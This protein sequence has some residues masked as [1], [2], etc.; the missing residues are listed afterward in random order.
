MEKESSGAV[1]VGQTPPTSAYGQTMQRSS[2]NQSRQT[3][4]YLEESKTQKQEAAI[5]VR[6]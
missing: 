3:P 5:R 4:S 2:Y 1:I 6:N